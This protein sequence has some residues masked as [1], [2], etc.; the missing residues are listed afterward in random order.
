MVD[1]TETFCPDLSVDRLSRFK[2][3]RD[4]EMKINDL[5]SIQ[6]S[7]YLSKPDKC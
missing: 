6:R 7:Y 2:I 4:Y 1:W 3:L 5:S